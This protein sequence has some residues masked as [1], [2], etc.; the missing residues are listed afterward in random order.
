MVP[1]VM[2]H[3]IKVAFESIQL[4]GPEPTDIEHRV[5][6]LHIRH[7]AYACQGIYRRAVML[8]VAVGGRT[9]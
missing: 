2:I 1:A 7:N 3:T 6:S 5:H 4:S 9:A 8:L